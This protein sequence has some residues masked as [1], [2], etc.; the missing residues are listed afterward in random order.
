MRKNKRNY[1]INFNLQFILHTSIYNM[2]Q[3]KFYVLY[4]ICLLD[5]MWATGF[6]EKFCFTWEYLGILHICEKTLKAEYYFA[7]LNN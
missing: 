2:K 3:N 1:H 7:T 4:L 6:Q 5:S